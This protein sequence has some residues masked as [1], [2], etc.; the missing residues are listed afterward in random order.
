MKKVSLTLLT[1][2]FSIG[3][4]A[5]DII[6]TRSGEDILAKILEISQTEVKYKKYDN[7]EGPTFTLLKSTLLMIRYD[8]GTKDIFNVSDI[9]HSDEDMNL[10]GIQDALANYRGRNSGA[11]WTAATTILFSPIIGVIPA[12]ICSSSAPTDKNLGIREYELMKD[13]KYSKA[14]IDQ[15]HKTKKG[16]IWKSFGIGTIIWVGF[17]L[18]ANAK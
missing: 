12:A 8:N 3:L 18:Q 5:Q 7:L 13:Y 9:G 15:A 4:F 17:V 16:K 6:T 10:R 2:F 1:L 11:G 14:Y